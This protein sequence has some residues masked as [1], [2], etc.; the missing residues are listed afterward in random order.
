MYKD[1][2]ADDVTVTE[3]RQPSFFY[4][5]VKSTQ[6]TNC[7]AIVLQRCQAGRQLTEELPKLGNTCRETASRCSGSGKINTSRR[8]HWQLAQLSLGKIY[9]YEMQWLRGFLV[10]TL[11]HSNQTTWLRRVRFASG[12]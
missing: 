10:S 6:K 5:A 9:V 7:S 12:F 1:R 3:P 11:S 8:E 2:T 4:T